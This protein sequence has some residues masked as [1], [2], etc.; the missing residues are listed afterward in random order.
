MPSLDKKRKEVNEWCIPPGMTS[1][2]VAHCF[3]TN[4]AGL[5]L[6]ILGVVLTAS[7]LPLLQTLVDTVGG[8]AAK[9]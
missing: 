6:A 9:K 2:Q 4:A 1:M 3:C 5:Q 8:R 7:E